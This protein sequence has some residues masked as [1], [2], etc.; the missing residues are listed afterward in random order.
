MIERRGEAVSS[1][2][3]DASQVSYAILDQSLWVRFQQA[4]TITAFLDSWLGLVARQVDGMATALLVTGETPDAGPF[5]AAARWPAGTEAA[6]DLAEAA[7]QAVSDRQSVVFGEGTERRVLAFPLIVF[8]GLFGAVAVSAPASA[9][10]TPAL[11]RRLH[12]GAAWIELLLRREQEEKDGELRERVTVSFDMLACLLEHDRLRDAANALVTE[13]ARRMDCETVSLGLRRGGRVRVQ[14]VSSAA[15]FGRRASLI[16]EVGLAMDEAVDQEAVILWPAPENWDF[17]VSRAAAD[18]AASHG[19]GSVLSIP[20]MAG[21]EI[22]GALTAERRADRPFTPLDVEV[23]DAVAAIAGPI[24]E[25]RRKDSRWLP[26]KIGVSLRRGLAALVGPRHFAAKLATLAVAALAAWL[27]YTPAQYAVSAPARLEGEVQRSVI[28]PF[29]GYLASQSARAGDLVTEGDILA[30]LDE[31]DL[32]LEQLR[33]ATARQQRTRELD[34][35]I[36]Q[37][38]VAEA[39][40]IRAQLEQTDA[41]LR[42]V[43]EQLARTRIR[44]PFSGYVVEGDLSQQVGGALERGQTLFRIAPLDGFRVMLEIDER[45]IAEITPGQE[46]SLRLSAFPE[47][48][49][50]YRVTRIT[51]LARQAEGRNFFLVEAALTG[52]TGRARPGMEG[53]SRTEI[54]ERRMAWV[55]FHDMVDWL[56]LTAWRWQ[57]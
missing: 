54:G 33:L 8:G 31:K 35:A 48:P 32:T 21:D 22:I 30:V 47:T 36:A 26:V 25:D 1:G 23:L 2:A 27:W 46:G 16:R 41:Q 49:Y 11:F 42:L 40:I 38:E 29:N 45:D 28:A 5:A 12:W 18:L 6:P 56:R 9:P 4:E 15:S 52:K 55:V 44:A 14:A 50:T 7:A 51:P 34:R 17:R 53:V 13:L 20:L 57:P 24:V 19:V 43:E 39:S 3:E 10:P 37:R